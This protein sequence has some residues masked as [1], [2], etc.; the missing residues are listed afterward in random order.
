[1]DRRL[2]LKVCCG[3]ASLALVSW[4]KCMC[5]W[6]T[7]RATLYWSQDL[8]AMFPMHD[9]EWHPPRFQFATAVQVGGVIAH[10]LF[11]SNEQCTCQS[12]NVA[13]SPSIR[14]HMTQWV[15]HGNGA[16]AHC[17]TRVACQSPRRSPSSPPYCKPRKVWY[18]LT[19]KICVYARSRCGTPPCLQHVNKMNANN[20]DL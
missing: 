4:W 2:G 15:I 11:N 7:V 9:R 14:W 10:I 18:C 19:Q 16:M 17:A 8:W 13:N 3:D 5:R 12:D 6:I 1:M 20:W